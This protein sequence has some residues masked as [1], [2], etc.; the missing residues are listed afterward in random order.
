[1]TSQ[2]AS[3]MQTPSIDP[4]GLR[5]GLYLNLKVSYS[6]SSAKL[7]SLIVLPWRRPCTL[8]GLTLNGEAGT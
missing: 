3:R 6:S 5:E 8:G 1:M 7:T 4:E 2:V